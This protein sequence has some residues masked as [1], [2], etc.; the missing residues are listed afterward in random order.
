MITK[1]EIHKSRISYNK[2]WAF[3]VWWDN[4]PYPNFISALYKT[5]KTA[6]V[7]L[8]EYLKSGKFDFYGDAEQEPKNVHDN[9]VSTHEH[10]LSHRRLRDSNL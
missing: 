9:P 6:T 8:K 7:K 3:S 1:T 2:G 5:K 10:G 4:R